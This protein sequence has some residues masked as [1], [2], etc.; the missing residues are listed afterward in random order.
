MADGNKITASIPVVCDCG[1]E[2]DSQL[3]PRTLPGGL[4]KDDPS[5][6][7]SETILDPAIP[8]DPSGRLRRPGTTSS[9]MRPLAHAQGRR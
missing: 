1:I 7:L 6:G 4:V 8:V 5:D 9:P 3:L 2:L